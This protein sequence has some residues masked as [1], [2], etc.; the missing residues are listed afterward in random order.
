LINAIGFSPIAAGN[1]IF[2]LN[3]AVIIGG[4]VWGGVS[5]KILKTRKWVVII[6]FLAFSFS[7]LGMAI[8]PP[9]SALIFFAFLFF[10]F[11]FSAGTANILFAHI[12]ELMP[13][14][15]AGVA[16]TGINFFTMIGAA[17]FVHGLGSLMQRL[18]PTA[19]LSIE[20]FRSAFILCAAVLL[21]ASVLY[22]FT[23][24]VVPGKN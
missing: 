14:K 9:G 22:L 6:S 5:D 24:D 11:G 8:L 2:L 18:Y 17:V 19:S 23:K 20:A 4:P 12:K 1:L 7:T 10:C 15:L 21:L 3:I 16:M 13:L